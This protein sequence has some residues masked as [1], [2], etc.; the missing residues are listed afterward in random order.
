MANKTDVV[1]MSELEPEERQIVDTLVE[2]SGATLL[3][4]S[5]L[6]EEGVTE[7]KTAACEKLLQHR[8]AVR[9]CACAKSK[10]KSKSLSA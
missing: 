5:A 8:V 1:K 4:M 9:Q 10:S 7:V 2:T 6:T 3:H